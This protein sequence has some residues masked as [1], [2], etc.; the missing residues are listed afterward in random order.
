MRKVLLLTTELFP[1]II[2]GGSL[3]AK[4]LHDEL[5]IEILA[6]KKRLKLLGKNIHQIWM[7]ASEGKPLLF[8][9]L[10]PFFLLFS[11]IFILKRRPKLIIACSK[12]YD[13][14]P[15]ILTHTP[16]IQVL[17]D[18]YPWTMGYISRPIAN[19]AIKYAKRVITPTYSTFHFLPENLKRLI[20][21]KHYV[22]SNPIDLQEFD[23]IGREEARSWLYNKLNIERDAKILLYVGY[24]SKSKGVHILLKAFR[25]YL[26]KRSD[27]NLILVGNIVDE[28]LVENLPPRTVYLGA[29]PHSM[30]LML[31]KACDVVVN[32]SLQMEGQGRTLLEG[33]AARRHVIASKI[34]AFMETGRE[35]VH[36]FEKGN[37]ESL[38]NILKNVLKQV[39]TGSRENII[40]KR[41]VQRYSLRTFK[42][43]WSKLLQELLQIYG[44]KS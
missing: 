30:L 36:Y 18:V 22:I 14:L 31:Y 40:A 6:P 2:T 26:E 38:K 4:Y 43:K 15:A 10:Y 25:C 21:Q 33:L 44:S 1:D 23:E 19:M 35:A 3:Y 24:I 27:V 28:E 39:D 16:F 7:P 32:P 42:N 9:L 13:A 8:I 34:P 5:E 12:V 20:K 17:H 29:I 11:I 37:L 41:V